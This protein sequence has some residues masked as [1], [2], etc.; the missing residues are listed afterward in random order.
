MLRGRE[1]EHGA[2]GSSGGFGVSAAGKSSLFGGWSFHTKPLSPSAPDGEN[3]VSLPRLL[4]APLGP[5]AHE[6]HFLGR[7]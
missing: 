3:R 4:G 7:S 6:A 2:A 1:G 5:A